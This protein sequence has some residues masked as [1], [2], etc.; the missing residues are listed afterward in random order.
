VVHGTLSAAGADTVSIEVAK[1]N[2]HGRRLV[3]DTVD[4]A[5]G[6]ATKVRRTGPAS[7]ADLVFG[8]RVKVQALCATAGLAARMIVAK[9]AAGAENPQGALDDSVTESGEDATQNGN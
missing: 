4:V 5:V 7:P 2:R 3:G 9:P 1:A 6:A 8:D